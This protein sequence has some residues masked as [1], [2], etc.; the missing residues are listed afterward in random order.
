[1]QALVCR[2]G[3]ALEFLMIR[4]KCSEAFV[5]CSDTQCDEGSVLVQQPRC[6]SCVREMWHHF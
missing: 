5:V 1:M 4:I 2:G 3:K 6:D